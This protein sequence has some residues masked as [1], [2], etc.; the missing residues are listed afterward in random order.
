MQCSF[1]KE[2]AVFEALYNGTS[3]CREHFF[4]SVEKRFRQ[5]LR[6]QI[7]LNGERTRISVAIS[8]GKDSSVLLYLLH[9][10]LSERRDI[11]LDAFTIDEGI[12][13][14]RSEGLKSAIELS[15][16][17]GIPHRTLSF[18][19][20]FG[21]DMDGIV[22]SGIE[23]TPCSRCGP[24]RRKLI[25][26]ASLNVNSNYVALGMN[27]DDYSQSVLMNVARGDLERTLRMAPHQKIDGTLV[28]RIVPL[29]R[30]YEKE[31]KLYAVLRGIPHDSGWCPYSEAAQRNRFRDILNELETISPG[32]KFSVL[33]FS[34]SLR[35]VINA[36]R[37]VT[38]GKCSLCGSPS[39]EEVCQ[40][41]KLISL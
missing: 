9:K 1:C 2:K 23:G 36:N 39:S 6:E 29:R 16:N 13:G 31:I 35:K 10:T 20:A 18:M 25:N 30:I 5:E 22:K 14:Y 19:E 4:N 32:T 26:E 37:L 11:M 15:S 38:I 21:R 28:P 12:E 41:C 34:D 8:G 17:L 40:T 27:L 3:L 7:S 24:M 33:N